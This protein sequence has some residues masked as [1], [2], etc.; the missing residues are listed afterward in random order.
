MHCDVAASAAKTKVYLRDADSQTPPPPPPLDDATDARRRTGATYLP[1]NVCAD[2]NG[3]RIRPRN[4]HV[5]VPPSLHHN[6]YVKAQ[7][8]RQRNVLYVRFA[9]FNYSLEYTNGRG[10][11]SAISNSDRRHRRHL[12]TF[13]D[14]C[15]I[16]SGRRCSTRNT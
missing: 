7:H 15:L 6:R 16:L 4:A 5:L 1:V 3:K 11:K 9:V 8:E 12:L 2:E 14:R 10:D 13:F